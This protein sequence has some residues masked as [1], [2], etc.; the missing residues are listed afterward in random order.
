MKGG[1]VVMSSVRRRVLRS[2]RS[3]TT[4][5]PAN[6]IKIQKRRARLDKERRSLG[7]WVSRLKR[8]FHAMERQQAKIAR[9]ERDLARQEAR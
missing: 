4:V 1:K 2:S 6:Q 8:A 9:L 5:D 3:I 7:R